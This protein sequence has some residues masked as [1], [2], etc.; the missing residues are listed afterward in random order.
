MVVGLSLK[1]FGLDTVH[2]QGEIWPY[3]AEGGNGV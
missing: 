3:E 1:H 2:S